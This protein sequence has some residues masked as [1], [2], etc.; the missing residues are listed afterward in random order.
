MKKIFLLVCALFVATVMTCAQVVIKTDVGDITMRLTGRTSFDVGSYTKDTPAGRNGVMLN[1]TRLGTML[2]FADKWNAHFELLLDNKS[3]SFR[4][5]TISYSFDDKH[6]VKIGNYFMPFGAKI[7]GLAYKFC[8]DASA[9]FA[10]TPNRKMGI[11]YFYT[12]DKLNLT[13][14]LFSDGN[15]DVRAMNQGWNLSGKVVYRPII[16]DKS[17]LH[18][19][20]APLYT[21]SPNKTDFMGIVP[22]TVNMVMIAGGQVEADNAM[23]LEGEALYINGRLYVEGRYQMAK[24]KTKDEAAMLYIPS[25][26][27]YMDCITKDDITVKGAYVQSSFLLIGDQQKYHKGMAFSIAPAPKSLELLMRVSCLDM[28][29][30]GGIK[31]VT[32]GLTYH[33]NKYLNAKV[34]LVYA[35]TDDDAEYCVG[36]GRLQFSF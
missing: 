31:D 7:T 4:D 36:Q 11:A 19:G 29:I 3:V 6:S 33:F 12:S 17:V 35:K 16:N 18:L 30:L 23:R 13:A 24:M 28:D 34:N 27:G 26:D 8:E 22:A 1:D 32:L 20:F 10:I 5:I 9:D 14:G 2:S 21:Q 25:A 15:A